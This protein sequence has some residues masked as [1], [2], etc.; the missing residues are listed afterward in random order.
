MSWIRKAIKGGFLFLLFPIFT[1]ITF[2]PYSLPWIACSSCNLLYC[3]GKRL[4][5]PILY[6]LIPSILAFGRLFCSF[7]CPSGT[8]QDTTNNI[9]RKIGGSDCKLYS[10]PSIKYIFLVF[11]LALCFD[12]E[13]SFFPFCYYWIPFLFIIFLF[14]SSFTNRYWC[15]LLCPIGAIASLGNIFAPFRIK[16]NKRLCM[17]CLECEKS[18]PVLCKP[19]TTTCITCYD[20]LFICKNK[21]ISIKILNK[22]AFNLME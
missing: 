15:K 8:I 20:C 21:A 1:P 22:Q 5:D 18:C 4:R 6:I 16:R 14:L 19:E 3:P 13:S 12:L 7:L 2:C 10:N 11:I 9:S 17:N